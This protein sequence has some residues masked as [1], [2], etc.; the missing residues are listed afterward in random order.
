MRWSASEPTLRPNATCWTAPRRA[1]SASGMRRRKARPCWKSF[2]AKHL[3]SRMSATAPGQMTSTGFCWRGRQNYEQARQGSSMSVLD[4][5]II[6]QML[7]NSQSRIR[8]AVSC[9]QEAPYTPSFSSL[10]DDSSFKQKISSVAGSAEAAVPV[11]P[12]DFSA[13]V[14][15]AAVVA[16]S[17]AAAAQTEPTRSHHLASSAS[18]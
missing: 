2:P 12:A 4:W 11:R 14:I 16:V 6:N 5:L 3:R 10:D 8:Q 13:A 9:S 7:T 17:A 18:R 15:Q 1:L